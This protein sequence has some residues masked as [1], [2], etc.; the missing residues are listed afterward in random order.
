[1]RISEEMKTEYELTPAEKA[2]LEDIDRQI[3]ML[4]RRK[5]DIYLCAR[6]KYITETPEEQKAVER[7]LMLRTM[8]MNGGLLKDYG[9][10]K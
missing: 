1:V 9:L 8:M 2:E 6:F 3:A 7:E 5:M 10:L 4:T